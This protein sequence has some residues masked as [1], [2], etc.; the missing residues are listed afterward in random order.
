MRTEDP[1]LADIERLTGLKPSEA[2]DEINAQKETVA[3]N[4]KSFTIIDKN[5]GK[6]LFD[7]DEKNMVDAIDTSRYEAI[8]T[9]EYN[10]RSSKEKSARDT[11]IVLPDNTSLK[12]QWDIV[13]ADSVKASLKEGQSQP[14]DRTRAVSNLQIQS[15]AN[16]PDYRRLSDSPVMDV[17]ASVLS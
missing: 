17:G 12:A 16:N 11:E 8:P 6:K 5:T 15:I 7:T 13:D 9:D 2:I 3:S 14:R 1:N 4:P 10:K